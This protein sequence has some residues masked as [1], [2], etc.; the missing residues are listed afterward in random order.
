MSRKEE[1]VRQLE[2]S[3]AAHEDQLASNERNI[4][5]L[6]ASRGLLRHDVENAASDFATSYQR[7]QRVADLQRSIA[8]HEDELSRNEE[9]IKRILKTQVQRNPP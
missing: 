3:I 2:R 7:T 6:L 1:Q 9:N 4:K 8:E 5:L